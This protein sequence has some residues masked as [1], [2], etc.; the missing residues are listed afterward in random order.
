MVTALRP[1][2]P[3][4]AII[5]RCAPELPSIRGDADQI[6][7]VVTNLLANA[8]KYSPTGGTITVSTVAHP[9]TVELLVADEGIGV[10]SEY[11]ER[12]FS[13][14][15]RISRPEQISIPGTG[16][17]LPIARQIVELH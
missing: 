16:L 11:Q 12:I 7:R 1:T 9:D 13:R 15:G 14:Y 4:H 6:T 3:Q 2:A 8:I 10:P 5:A 17:G